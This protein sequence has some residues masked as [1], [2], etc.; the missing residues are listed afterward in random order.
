MRDWWRN[1][2][3]RIGFE[4]MLHPIILGRVFG[5]DV[6]GVFPRNFAAF[7]RARLE[8]A[9]TSRPAR[10]N[11]FLWQL[12]LQEFPPDESA[13][14]RWLTPEGLEV[15][16]RRIEGVTLQH[17]DAATALEAAPAQ[18]FDLI[19]L[20]NVL[21]LATQQQIIELLRVAGRAIAPA[22]CVVLRFI[23]PID[24][25]WI[26][27]AGAGV[28]IDWERTQQAR[29]FERGPFCTE[30]FVLRPCHR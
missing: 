19:A 24:R 17:S 2:V 25:T 21:E 14:P 9:M 8:T 28:R 4:V 20:S 12:Y 10:A 30:I 1:W 7:M 15:L 5:P 6:V 11:P 23:L 22:G 26:E 27:D 16:R 29:R 13:W 18:S 3:W